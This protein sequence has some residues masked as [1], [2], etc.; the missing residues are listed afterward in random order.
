MTPISTGVDYGLH[1]LLF[2]VDPSGSAPLASVYGL[3]ELKDI[4]AG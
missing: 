2:L 1:C 4:P 3:A